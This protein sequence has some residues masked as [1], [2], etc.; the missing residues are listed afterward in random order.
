M[1][2][3]SELKTR[4]LEDSNEAVIEGYFAVYDQET[5]LF[6]GAFEEIA[7]GSLDKSLSE[8]DVLALDNHDST[9]VL[10]S[11]G[12]ETLELKSDEKGLYGSIKIDLEDPFAKSAYR[13]VQTGKIR[14]CSFGFIPIREDTQER[15]DGTIKW[16]VQEAELV[17][18]SITAFPAYPQTDIAARRKDSDAIKLQKLNTRKKALKERIK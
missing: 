7:R 6:E 8:N 17:E 11:V 1:Q 4:A 13:K 10:G 18:V 2:V 16:V 15:E 3:R 5:E 14:G 12:S 9:I